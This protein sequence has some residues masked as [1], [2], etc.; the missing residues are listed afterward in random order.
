MRLGELRLTRYRQFIDEKLILDP[1]VT[2]I[3]GRNDTGKTGL[4]DHFFDQCVYEGV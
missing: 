2:A 1:Y 3:V 4:L